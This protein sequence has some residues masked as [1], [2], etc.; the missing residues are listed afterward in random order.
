MVAE[1]P[2][3]PTV[4]SCNRVPDIVFQNTVIFRIITLRKPNKNF[5]LLPTYKTFSSETKTGFLEARISYPTALLVIELPFY[6]IIE[7]RKRT[8]TVSKYSAVAE[9]QI[10]I[11]DVPYSSLDQATGCRI[12]RFL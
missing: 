12:Y 5:L 10:C 7:I 3:S 8:C 11:H 2:L 1:I 6:F 4:T 9:V